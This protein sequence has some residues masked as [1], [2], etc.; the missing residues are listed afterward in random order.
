MER[1]IEKVY[2]LSTKELLKAMA[3]YGGFSS[4]HEAYSVIKE[5]F[6]ET[7]EELEKAAESISKIWTFVR[8][9]ED[10]SVRRESKDLL[11]ASLKTAAEAVQLAAMARKLIIYLEEDEL[12][13]EENE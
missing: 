10:E 7:E 11:R 6:E 8:N 4:K 2:D 13:E 5:E 1:I 12:E 9:D 3:F